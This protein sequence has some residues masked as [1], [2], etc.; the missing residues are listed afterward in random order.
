M[1]TILITGFGPFPGAS[2][3]PT[4]PLV[5]HLAR[6]RRPGLSGVRL[7]GHVFAT[8]YAAVDRD[9]P[10]LIARHRPAAL[11]MF[12]VAMRRTR[13]S[14]ELRAR[15]AL[16]LLPDA[17]RS[18][19]ARRTIA[20]HAAS[21][22]RLPMP[23]QALLQAARSARVSAALSRDSGRYLCNYAC[24]RAAESVAESGGPRLAAFVHVPPVSRM[25]RPRRA[26]RKLTADD[27]ARAGE[28]MLM[29]LAAAARRR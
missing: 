29:A 18:V 16:A 3:N 9:L 23:P 28:A 22:R 7:A 27:L 21:E 19:L 1:I 6:L 14:I 25:L 17:S 8:S 15:N 13:L 24:W 20:P 12:G 11:L 10:D 26:R 5:A 2:V 4:A